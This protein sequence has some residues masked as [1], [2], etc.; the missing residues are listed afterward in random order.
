MAFYEKY[1]PVSMRNAKELEFMRLQQGNMSAAEYTAKFEEL[2]KFSIIYQRNPHEGWKCV[3]FERGLGE[4]I[5]PLVGSMETKEY[6]ALVNKSGLVEECNKKLVAT[7]SK[8]YKKKLE[9]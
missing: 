9:P 7:R 4:D 8:A 1:F 2:C 6:T 3:K 5:L